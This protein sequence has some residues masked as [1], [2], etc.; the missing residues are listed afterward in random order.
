[1]RPALRMLCCSLAAFLAVAESVPAQAP[2]AASAA[3]NQNFHVVI[4]IPV[5]VVEHMRDRAWL[6]SSWKQI[7][8]GVKVDKVYIETYRSR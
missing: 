1:M 8:S 3:A 4:Y 5:A 7:S 6:E 2:A